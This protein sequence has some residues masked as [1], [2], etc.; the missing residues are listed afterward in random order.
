MKR[1][2][3]ALLLMCLVFVNA[4]FVNVVPSENGHTLIVQIGN[5]RN[6]K[7]TIQLQLYK[8]QATYSKE[9]PWKEYY[10]SKDDLNN[11]K[12]VYRIT[13]LESGIY[14]V[15]ILDDEDK[16]K[17]MKFSWMIPDEGFGFSDYYHVGMSRP[18]FDDFKFNLTGDKTVKVIIRYM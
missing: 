18:K 9:T 13:G 15:A 17:K 10:V 8:N 11:K 14:G 3:F 2:V 7:G 16:D 1:F 12:L 6:S 5:I 4:S